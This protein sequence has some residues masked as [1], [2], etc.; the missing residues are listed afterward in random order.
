MTEKITNYQDLFLAS[1]T[2]KNLLTVI[3]DEIMAEIAKRPN[4]TNEG[5]AFSADIKTLLKQSSQIKQWAFDL[6]R[7]N[8][9]PSVSELQAVQNI[10]VDNA[11]LSRDNRPHIMSI[12][13]SAGYVAGGQKILK[14]FGYFTILQDQIM[15]SIAGMLI[16]EMNANRD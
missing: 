14:N 9:S 13:K 6:K 3:H 15:K 11:L 1:S 8:Y 12:F 5:A 4:L 10:L 7:L 16:E 2:A